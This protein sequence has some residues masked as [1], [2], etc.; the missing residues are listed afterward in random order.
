MTTP[1]LAT[2]QHPRSPRT[3]QPHRTTTQVRRSNRRL[4][5]A[6]VRKLA[7]HYIRISRPRPTTDPIG[8]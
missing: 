7:E 8:A 3:A 1:M 6:E 4:E 5:Q 2:I